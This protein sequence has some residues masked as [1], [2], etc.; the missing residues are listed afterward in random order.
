MSGE[1]GEN[2][3][4]A[5]LESVPGI[6]SVLR[7]PVADALV[8]MIKAGARQGPFYAEDAEELVQY[9]VRRKIIGAKEG[10]TLLGD[11]TKAAKGTTRP[12]KVIIRPPPSEKRRAFGSARR[13]APAVTPAPAVKP[14]PVKDAKKATKKVA[15]KATKTT[16][17]KKVVVKKKV[18][19]KKKATKT[20][21]KNTKKRK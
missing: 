19:A 1:L 18:V 20:A 6:A 2:Q 11:V 5:L 17:K 16:A 8:N 12:P 10:E 9:A 13:V 3:I 4:S 15:K 14:T 21:K 7:N